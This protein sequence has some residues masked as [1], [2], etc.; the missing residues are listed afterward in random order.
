MFTATILLQQ[1]GQWTLYF[2]HPA[3]CSGDFMLMDVDSLVSI[4]AILQLTLE[5]LP[6]HLGKGRG[7]VYSV[8]WEGR[9]SSGFL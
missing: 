6:R 7:S 1:I 5:Q 9:G 2:L 3:C 8:E 4:I